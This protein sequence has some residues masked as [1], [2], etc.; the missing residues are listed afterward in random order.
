M[1]ELERLKFYTVPHS[2]KL[3]ETI[4]RLKAQLDANQGFVYSDENLKEKWEEEK[5]PRGQP[6]NAGQFVEKAKQITEKPDDKVSADAPDEVSSQK[7]IDDAAPILPAKRDR[8]FEES[9][10]IKQGER[11]TIR[12]A[13]KAANPHYNDS[14]AFQENCSF[15]VFAYDMLKRGYLVEAQPMPADKSKAPFTNV[16]TAYKD[17]KLEQASKGKEDLEE[18]LKKAD[19]PA[20]SR[21]AVMVNRKGNKT[22]HDFIAEKDA[23]GEIGFR[24]SQHGIDDDG[25]VIDASHYFSNVKLD[26]DGKQQLWFA[27]IDNAEVNPDIDFRQAV[28][29]AEK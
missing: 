5:H 15:A 9:L 21:F 10:Q 29:V 25:K 6:G 26:A 17:L 13:L 20:G 2:R 28:K 8:Y 18:R 19:F 22:G 3:R 24:N 11:A 16:F 1:T 12:Q 23:N 27:R 7:D 14:K 4:A